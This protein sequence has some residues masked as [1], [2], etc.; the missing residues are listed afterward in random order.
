MGIA[1]YMKALDN[2]DP[3]AALDQISPHVA[4]VFKLP[5][6]EVRGTSKQDFADYIANRNP[7]ERVHHV[8][9]HQ[10]DGDVEFVYGVVT[11]QGAPTGAFLSAAR[12][13]PDGKMARYFTSFDTEL[14]L[15]DEIG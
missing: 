11:Q 5:G 2:N 14:T 13:T 15:T 4:F 6:T 1:D 3:A 7:V 12:L 10:V 8:L 9:R